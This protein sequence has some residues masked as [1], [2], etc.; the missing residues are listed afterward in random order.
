MRCMTI[1]A[2]LLLNS[3]CV[4]SVGT[5]VE[6]LPEVVLA[7]KKET[8]TKPAWLNQP[9]GEIA[10]ETDRV[11]IHV[12]EDYMSGLGR[13]ACAIEARLAIAEYMGWMETVTK[14]TRNGSVKSYETY[15]RGVTGLTRGRAIHIQYF[16]EHGDTV[17]CF[18]SAKKRQ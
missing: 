17:H 12:I 7:T 11:T 15:S 10:E 1:V 5:G 18:G 3:G 4:F 14:R 16:L 2:M 6:L 8:N 13:S 9:P